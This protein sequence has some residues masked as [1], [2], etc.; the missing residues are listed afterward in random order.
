MRKR[1][2]WKWEDLDNSSRRIKVIGGWIVQTKIFE[3][4]KRGVMISESSVFVAD[5]DHEWEIMPEIKDTPP[6][7]K[8]DTAAFK[9]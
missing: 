6:Q 5:R 3:E 8:L 4:S 1:I 7:A 2:E 9:A